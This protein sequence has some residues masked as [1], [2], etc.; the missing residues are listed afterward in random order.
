[1]TPQKVGGRAG[2]LNNCGYSGV[3]KKKF[4]NKNWTPHL[5][6][7]GAAHASMACRCLSINNIIVQQN[8][9][10]DSSKFKIGKI[11]VLR[12]FIIGQNV[13]KSLKLTTLDSLIKCD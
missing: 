11:L 13:A 3:L 5:Q 8:D 9:A 2:L 10:N 6:N 12:A 1:M 7:R 4:E